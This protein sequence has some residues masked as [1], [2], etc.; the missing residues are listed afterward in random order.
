MVALF[1]PNCG[2]KFEKNN[3]WCPVCGRER[4]AIIAGTL[5]EDELNRA[6]EFHRTPAGLDRASGFQVAPPPPQ[7]V[8]DL[9][10]AAYSALR[11]RG[12]LWIPTWAWMALIALLCLSVGLGI[13][14]VTYRRSSTYEQLYPGPIQFAPQQQPKPQPPARDPIDEFVKASRH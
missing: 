13:G 10:V 8:V 12:K 4:D 5:R 2:T 9:H 14:V 11:K 1:C 7:P 6:G 3:E